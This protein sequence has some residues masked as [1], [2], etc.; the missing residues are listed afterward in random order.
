MKKIFIVI[1]CFCVLKANAQTYLISFTGT[2]ASTTVGSVKVD[3]LTQGTTLTINGSDIL[4][5][6]I[7]TGINSIKDIQNSELKIYPNPMFDNSTLEICPPISGNATISVYDMTGKLVAQIQNYLENFLQ[8][9]SL[10]GLKNGFYF[11]NVKGDNYQFSGKLISNGISDRALSI[12]RN[13]VITPAVYKKAEKVESKGIQ[14]TVDM[15]YTTGDRLKFTG[16]FG[17]YSTVMTDIPTSNKLVTFNFVICTDGDNNNYPIIEIGT[18][19]WM[20]ENLKT[21]KYNDGTAI[22][23]V[24]DNTAW[25]LL[26]TGAYSDYSNTPSN[27]TTYGRLYNWYTI[28]NNAATKV[29]S[30][31]GKNVCPT[32]W[33]VFNDVDWTTLTDYLTNN[34]YGYGGT[35][36]SIAKSMASISGWTTI[37]TPGYVGNEQAKNNSSGFNAPPGGSRDAHGTF[38]AIGQTAIWWSTSSTGWLDTSSFF[39]FYNDGIIYSSR[40]LVNQQ[41]FSVRCIKD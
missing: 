38:S 9:Y 4:R 10:S 22:P 27:S 31:G 13:N 41:S 7:T 23:N 35:G 29:A 15:K 1:A 30:N 28:D 32:G 5:L 12:D 21:T 2:G 19:V 25:S 40:Y 33:R 17:N 16:I 36:N 24:T 3:N 11:I 8:T 18:Q 34:G 14:S 6:N 39:I 26:L 20:A 37:G